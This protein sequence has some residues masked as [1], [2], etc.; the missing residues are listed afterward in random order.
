MALFSA[1]LFPRSLLIHIW[2]GIDLLQF[3][4]SGTLINLQF[5]NFLAVVVRAALVCRIQ[6]L[7]IRDKK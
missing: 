7:C 5:N 4:V 2:E 1:P 6:A 3:R